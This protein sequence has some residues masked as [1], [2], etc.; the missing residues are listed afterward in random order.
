MVHHVTF[1]KKRAESFF[2]RES[3]IRSAMATIA[4]TDG[5]ITVLHGVSGAGKTSLCMI[6]WI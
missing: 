2:G 3:L 4:A 1:V 5:K 6:P